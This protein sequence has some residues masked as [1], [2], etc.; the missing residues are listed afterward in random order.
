MTGARR[1]LFAPL[2]LCVL[3]PLLE[4]SAATTSPEGWKLARPDYVWSFPE[5]HRAHHGYRTEWWY[6]TGQLATPE[7]RR[8]GYQFTFFR[9][10]LVPRQDRD[11]T[12]AR[13]S[14]WSSDEL[15]MGHASIGD[16]EGDEHRFSEV[17]YR[18]TPFLG[19]F[20]VAPD[21]R[22][23][24]SLAP[25]GTDA[26]WSVR[27]NGNGFDLSMRDDAKRMAFDLTTDAARPLVF[28]GPN[29]YSRKSSDPLA[30]A[31][32]QYYSFT[33][34][35]T[36]GSLELDGRKLAVTGLSWMDKEFGSSHL[37]SGQVGWDWFSLQLDDGRDVMLYLLRRADDTTDGARGTL[38]QTDPTAAVRYLTD[39]DWSLRS[40][41]RWKSPRTEADYP[42][43]W[44]ITVRNQDPKEEL[45]LIVEPEMADQENVGRLAG[46]LFYWE[47]A[48]RVLDLQG[49]NV[50]HGYVELVGYGRGNRPPI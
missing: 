12:A 26:R 24:W 30:D 6:F 28:Q 18:V 34:L 9:V 19:G 31:A 5:D 42:A 14:D 49:R 13:G 38:I 48:V 22:L 46:G 44:E 27:W 25:A 45:R 7:G 10:G 47:G 15:I 32:S 40:T 11:T 3:L 41:R 33:R 37:D 50:G 1:A 36:R 43:R 23:A 35:D 2:A 20:P 8:F 16:L 17:L 21:P 39:G 4:S 29:G